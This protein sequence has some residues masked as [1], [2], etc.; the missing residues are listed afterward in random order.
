MTVQP[1]PCV[2][3][4]SIVLVGPFI[5]ACIA[6]KIFNDDTTGCDGIGIVKVKEENTKSLLKR[7]EGF[8]LLP[9]PPKSSLPIH[10]S[11]SIS[12]IASFDSNESEDSFPDFPTKMNQIHPHLK[13]MMALVQLTA[14]DQ[15][16]LEDRIERCS[17]DFH[18]PPPPVL[19]YGQK[20]HEKRT[21]VKLQQILHAPKP[22]PASQS[23]ECLKC[24]GSGVKVGT[25]DRC[26]DCQGQ[27]M[28][29]HLVDCRQCK[30]KGFSHSRSDRI[31]QTASDTRCFYCTSCTSCLGKKEVPDLL[32]K[33]PITPP[34]SPPMAL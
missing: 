22:L 24:H 16:H 25:E 15:N 18:L 11:L 1:R 20:K 19:I 14:E 33:A 26:K 21:T 4:V 34:Y 23:K 32:L 27:G 29:I 10:K 28:Q 17:S 30:G 5:Y 7:L 31:H 6:G 9:V 3:G 8:P 2:S 12:S 13:G